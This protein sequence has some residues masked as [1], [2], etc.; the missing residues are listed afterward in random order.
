[1]T[2]VVRTGDLGLDLLLGGGWQIVERLP[3]RHSATVVVRGGPG[4]GKTL[5]ALQ[6]AL[7]LAE[8]LG[9]DVAVGCVE[10][11][12]SEYLAQVRS[13]RSDI[14]ETR[15]VV[16]PQKA[17]E[18]TEPRVFCGLLT[19]LEPGAPDLVASLETLGCDVA[20][21]GGR[22]SVF[23][24]D[25]LI[26]GYGIGETA[27]RA[28]ADAV[29]KFAAQGGHGLVLCE[30]TRGEA[31]SGWVFAADTV[32]EL[33]V[34]SRER[35]RWIEV[36]KHRFAA[37]VSG[38]HELE[39]PGHGSPAVYPQPQAWVAPPAHHLLATVGWRS[40]YGRGETA[41]RW[42]DSF[43]PG[44]EKSGTGA[45]FVGAFA[46]VTSALAGLAR[47]LAI[48]LLPH[49]LKEG[50]REDLLIEFDPLI[51]QTRS[52]VVGALITQH[53][54]TMHGAARALREMIEMFGE[55]FSRTPGMS[56]PSIRR[57][58]IGD[59][60]L[61]LASPDALEWV[62]AVRV[63]V[64]LVTGSGW[65]IPVVVFEEQ[66]PNP[67]TVLA[68]AV[69]AQHADLRFD[70]SLPENRAKGHLMQ[71]VAAERWRRSQRMFR[72]PTRL[73]ASALPPDLADFDRLPPRTQ[74][75]TSPQS[76]S[77]PPPP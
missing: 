8:A 27:P 24:V 51:P 34:T 20:A 13:A 73:D 53:V 26:E 63:F 60:R 59:V 45:I 67:S 40:H 18:S 5:M 48:G 15:I 69:L 21:A 49:P 68:H 66:D 43:Q 16:L 32:L 77:R 29:M 17:T 38:R 56:H 28:S 31:A 61:V 4:V 39:I 2:R 42:H 41:L 70:V 22:P 47:T 33:G 54:P 7:K 65:G 37:S 9:G 74:G 30:E 46:L 76:P 12:P 62:E 23:V 35:G 14:D 52:W 1:L 36:R 11:L 19:D 72:W 58:L 44:A 3:E 57:V 55:G 10:I 75:E 25:S 6:V 71:V 64:S 50:S